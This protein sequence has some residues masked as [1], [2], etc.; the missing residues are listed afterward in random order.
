MN[1]TFTKAEDPNVVV[2][3]L[4]CPYKAVLYVDSSIQAHTAAA[5]HT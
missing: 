4:Y 3:L 2:H 1:C 5:Q